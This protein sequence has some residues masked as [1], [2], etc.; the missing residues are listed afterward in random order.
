MHDIIIIGGGI[1]G[2]YLLKTLKEK[3][4][5]IKISLLERSPFIGG[6]IK[7]KYNKDKVQ[8]ETG[9]WRFHQSHQRLL[10]LIKELNLTYHKTTSTNANIEIDTCH[11]SK[12]SKKTLKISGLSYKDVD[13]YKNSNCSEK[14]IIKIPPIMD[15][16]VNVY[17]I[18]NENEGT[19]YVL[20]QGFTHFIKKLSDPYL[21]DILLNCLVSDVKQKEDIYEIEYKKRDDN[22]YT[23]H[24]LQCHRLILC[25]PAEVYKHWTISQKYLLPLLN[26]VGTI[27]LHHIYGYSKNV[28]TFHNNKFL[29]QTDNTLSSI[30]SGDFNNNWFQISYSSGDLAVFLNRLKLKY[31][32]K[33]KSFLNDNLKTLN[34][35]LQASKIENHFWVNAIHYWKSGFHF[36]LETNVK[37]SIYPHPVKLKNLWI[38]GESFSS[39]QGWIEGALETSNMV[40]NSIEYNLNNKIVFKPISVI[41]DNFVYL[42]DRVLDILKWKNLHPGSYK[43]ISNHK[44]EDISNLFRHIGHSEDAWAIVY[45]IQ[46]YWLMNEKIGVFMVKDI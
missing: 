33:F 34:I 14:K 20:D 22:R 36:D 5:H 12:T 3:Y 13:L 11:I 32:S 26:S 10:K 41:K 43:A 39:I 1:S 4:K 42:D 7:T 40:L 6:K 46:K 8:Y 19:Y 18:K 24:T 31:P 21:N 37:N 45:N 44:N 15:S 9:P 25:I 16:T 23:I 28:N 35:P 27:P 2:I 38:A 30:I 29:I 17:D